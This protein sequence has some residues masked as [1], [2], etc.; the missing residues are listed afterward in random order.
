MK[1]EV[2]YQIER[3]PFVGT[4]WS[5]RKGTEE[6]N[7]IRIVETKNRIRCCCSFRRTPWKYLSALIQTRNS[8]VPVDSIFIGLYLKTQ[9]VNDDFFQNLRCLFFFYRPKKKERKSFDGWAVLFAQQLTVCKAGGP[10]RPGEF[11]YFPIHVPALI[12]VC[13]Q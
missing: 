7:S 8:F 6:P 5:I 9:Q 2:E 1:I 10:S 11:L 3:P 4:G 13:V 12:V